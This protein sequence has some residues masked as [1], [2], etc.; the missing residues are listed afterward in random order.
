MNNKLILKVFMNNL[1]DD[2][3]DDL[4]LQNGLED[5]WI[6]VQWSLVKVQ[7]LVD[8]LRRPMLLLLLLLVMLIM[9]III[10]CGRIDE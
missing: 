3:D 1:W 2:D 10:A 6:H 9:F 4:R 8:Q 5:F 7:N